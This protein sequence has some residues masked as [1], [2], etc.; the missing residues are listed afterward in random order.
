MYLLELPYWLGGLKIIC[1]EC[2][3]KH[4][5]LSTAVD[6]IQLVPLNVFIRPLEDRN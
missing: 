2:A 4:L 5:A 1:K 6:I 3:S